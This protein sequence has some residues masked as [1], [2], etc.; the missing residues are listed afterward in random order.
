MVRSG[1]VVYSMLLY[2]LV[3]SFSPPPCLLN[4][5]QLTAA[6]LHLPFSAT[7]PNDQAATRGL[8]GPN[9]MG[10]DAALK[11]ALRVLVKGIE[12]CEQGQAEEL[13][14]LYLTLYALVPGF[15]ADAL[16]MAEE[17]IE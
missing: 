12:K 13:W 10:D 15:A 3:L 1:S 5:I 6:P 16:S 2:C 11:P 4:T 17:A 9:E 14:A 7:T 8:R